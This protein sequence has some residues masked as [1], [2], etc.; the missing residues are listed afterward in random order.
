MTG[1]TFWFGLVFSFLV[2]MSGVY[3]LVSDPTSEMQLIGWVLVVVGNLSLG[4][5]MAIRQRQHRSGQ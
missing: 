4:T 2:A 5:N 1:V 3:I